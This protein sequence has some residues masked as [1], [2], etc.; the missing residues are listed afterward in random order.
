MQKTDNIFNK[1]HK[2]ETSNIT[3]FTSVLNNFLRTNKKENKNSMN[4]TMAQGFFYALSSCPCIIMPTD[5]MLVLFGGI[6]IFSS[7]EEQKKISIVATNLYNFIVKNLLAKNKEQ[8]LFWTNDG[9][10]IDITNA[11][12]HTIVDFCVGYI[13]GY[14]LDPIINN[15]ITKTPDILLNFLLALIKLGSKK[16]NIAISI[17]NKKML[18]LAI[19]QNYEN[20]T[21]TRKLHLV[22]KSYLQ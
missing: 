22:R 21:N 11:T 7:I 19:T 2:A 13:K 20:W 12:N 8:L 16:N 5:W 9:I 10:L 14:L 1:L 6:P 3:S 15:A 18:E 17:E 4:I